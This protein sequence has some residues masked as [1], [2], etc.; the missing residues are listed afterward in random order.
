MYKPIT[1]ENSQLYL[2]RYRSNLSERSSAG[3]ST[4]EVYSI[5]RFSAN[6]I[7]GIGEPGNEESEV[8]KAHPSTSPSG[9]TIT[10]ASTLTKA[11]PK[12]TPVYILS[13]DQIQF[14]HADTTMKEQNLNQILTP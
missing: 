12:D 2:S 8:I 9:T 6:I 10:L 7:L 5:E 4:I 13:F 11:H 14:F 3:D 1:A